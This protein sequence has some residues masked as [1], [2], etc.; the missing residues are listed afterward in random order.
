MTSRRGREWLSPVAGIGAAVLF[1][2][3]VSG[4]A[5][6]ARAVE[7]AEMLADPDLETRA[8]AVSQQLRCVVC[9]NQSIDDSNAE[10]ARDMRVLVRER[11]VAGDTDADVIWFL[12]ERYGDFVTLKP[13]FKFA[14]G[15][16]WLGPLLFLLLA[17]GMMWRLLARSRGCMN[18][19]GP[20]LSDDERR[21]LRTLM[22][23]GGGT[24]E[25]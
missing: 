9:Q 16:L 24:N 15:L 5:W 2:G 19:G 7:P 8:R 13:P 1:C 11:I 25:W 21:R 14:T 10:L 17:A 18:E 22:Q 6:P 12:V 3:L 23:E 4:V 20:P